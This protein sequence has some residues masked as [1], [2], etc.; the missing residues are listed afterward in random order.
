MGEATSDFLVYQIDPIIAVIL[1]AIGLTVAM[2]L[3]LLVSQYVPG[4]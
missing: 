1:G 4:I 3:Q 2:A